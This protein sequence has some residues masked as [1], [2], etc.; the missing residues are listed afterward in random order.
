MIFQKMNNVLIKHGKSVSLIFLVI[1]IIAFVWYFTPGVD[2]SILFGRR[3][4]AGA[5]YG[6]AMSEKIS[7]ADVSHAINMVTMYTAAQY[8]AA[9]N[10]I[11]SIR[12]EEGFQV[13][14]LI[15]I[16][17]KLG[18]QVSDKEIAETLR[19]DFPVFQTDGKFD[20]KLYE[21]YRDRCLV[22]CGYNFSDFEKA[23]ATVLRIGKVTEYM[24]E[25]CVITD[26]ELKLEVARTLEKTNY[27]M[28]TFPGENFEDDIK[29]TDDEVKEYYTANPASFMTEPVSYGIIAAA[30]AETDV[31]KVTDEQVA[32]YYELVKDTLKDADGKE[33]T[34][35]DAKDY[36]KKV[37]SEEAGME[38]A[39]EKIQ[40]F[41]KEFREF[42][43]MNKEDYQADAQGVF[44]KYADENGLK[45]IQNVK[46]TPTMTTDE[47]SYID[48]NL[49]SAATALK[50]VN[51]YTNIVTGS[52]ACTIFLLTAVEPS[53]L[54]AF[55]DVQDKA[56]EQLIASRKSAMAREHSDEFAKNAAECADIPG[57]LE[58][59]VKAA[60]GTLSDE[61]DFTAA[62]LQENPYMM[63]MIP[64][65]QL[66]NTDI[67][68]L[69]TVDMTLGSPRYVY[70]ISRTAPTEEEI[71]KEIETSGPG[72]LASKQSLQKRQIQ[73]WLAQSIFTTFPTRSSA[74]QVE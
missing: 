57:K 42:V 41:N 31:S 58:E 32:D 59:L 40:K 64:L 19:N 67:G 70:I 5:T 26:S 30:V 21:K 27:K 74:D 14:A 36:I 1:I 10:R 20:A 39:S 29:V 6:Q 65:E 52:N 54:A 60:K 44:R 61:L 37:L 62:T 50:N 12:E 3:T 18:V 17:D 69:S 2:G 35:E 28:V 15:A 72:A 33:Q 9:P 22:P 11:A 73:N 47:Q 56:K 43:R 23:I 46:L 25:S 8:G 4:G 53:A 7:Y 45:I 48:T 71:A 16:A 63:Y 68:K 55:S 24:S 13:A 38:K 51:S 66:L 49:I 34:L